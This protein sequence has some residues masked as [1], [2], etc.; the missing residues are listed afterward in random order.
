MLG[1][2]VFRFFTYMLQGGR[3]SFSIIFLSFGVPVRLFYVVETQGRGIFQDI[4]FAFPEKKCSNLLERI[5]K[6]S[7]FAPA[8]LMEQPV[9]GLILGGGDFYRSDL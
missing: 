3:I 1:N 6:V 4:L 5:E 8:F 2:L 7:I 9:F